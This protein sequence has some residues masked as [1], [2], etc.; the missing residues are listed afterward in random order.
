MNLIAMNRKLN[1][2]KLLKCDVDRINFELV[3][4]MHA[5]AVYC[6]VVMRGSFLARLDSLTHSRTHAH[7]TMYV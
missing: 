6:N 2:L 3:Q 1:V 5:A 4:R 7:S